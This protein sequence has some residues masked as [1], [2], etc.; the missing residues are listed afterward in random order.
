MLVES[1]SAA[2][3]SRIG[4]L[5]IVWGLPEPL[6]VAVFEEA[7]ER[8]VERHPI[9]RTQLVW[10]GCAEPFQEVVRELRLPFATCDWTGV[11]PE[12]QEESLQTF[13]LE[14]R[15]RGLDLGQAPLLRVTVAR[16]GPA[17]YRV[18]LTLHHMTYDGRTVLALIQEVFA[19]YG[20]LRG[21]EGL[22]LSAPGSYRAY[23]E[24]VGRQD[25][26][27][28][29][30]FWRE[31]L[32]GIREPTPLGLDRREHAHG[33]AEGEAAQQVWF[34]RDFSVW[35]SDGTTAALLR[36]T[37]D[38][39]LTLNTLLLGA[40]SL[41]LSRY[42]GERDVLF[43]V[44]RTHRGAVE[45]GVAI[46]GPMMNSVPF[47]ATVDPQTS[48]GSWLQGL[49]AHWLA[50]RAGD[51]ATPAQIRS[52][53][54][55]DPLAPLFES[56]ALF[57]THEL[58]ERLRQQGPDWQNRSFRLFR[59][60]RLPVSVYGYY[61]K[62]LSLKVIFDPE[63]FDP[64]LMR[65]LLGHLRAAVEAMP[66][67]I[68]RGVGEL[69]LLTAPERRQLLA[70]WNDT[71]GPESGAA[72]HRRFEEHARRAP[73][74]LAAVD[75]G[76]ACS[77]GEMEARANQLAW[78]LQKRGVRPGSIVGVLLDRSIEEVQALLGILK[79]GGAC[80]P[81]EGS[82]PERVATILEDADVALLLT[83]PAE[84][85]H[86]RFPAA[87]TLDLGAAREE[88]RRQPVSPPPVRT[89]AE[90][91][92]YVFYTSGS[93]GR[94]KGVPI[95]HRGLANLIEWHRDAYGILSADRGSRLAGLGFDASMWELWPFWS[96]GGTVF[97]PPERIR[98]APE[99][100]MDWWVRHEVTVANAATPMAE[101]LLPL[102]WPA[103]LVIRALHS[104]GDTLRSGPPEDLPF[105]FFN[106][107]GPTE[108]TC[109]ATSWEV[110]PDGDPRR[111]GRPPG[112]GRPLRNTRIYLLDPELRP[113]PIGVRGEL[114]IAGHG[115]AL[116]YLGRPE[117]TAASFV[118]DPYGG[119]GE[120]MYRTGDLARFHPDGSLEFLGR[121]DYQI[122]VRGFRIEPGEI[123][124][125][126]GRYPALEASA[127]VARDGARPG[128]KQLV[129]FV[130]G[131]P[132]SA[133]AEDELK[134][135]LR[136]KLP[137]YMIPALFVRL[138]SLPLNASAKV[139]RRA[140]A[141]EAVAVAHDAGQYVPPDTALEQLL[142][143]IWGQVLGQERVGLHDD[144]YALGGHSLHIMQVLSSV[145]DLFP[146]EMPVERAF[147]ASTI[148]QLTEQ[149]F[150]GEF[151]RLLAEN[152]AETVLGR[153]GPSVAEATGT[154]SG[155]ASAR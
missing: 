8:V 11:P 71:A 128:D 5:Q 10:L 135:F 142:A 74:A 85:P 69:P 6:D 88:L 96:A 102:R 154:L 106:V 28:A 60:G 115:L 18:I 53:S 94:P 36:L 141:A 25:H 105:P 123:E 91:P 98:F 92:A 116:G 155:A 151:E 89:A 65:R 26:R 67:G 136:G 78:L 56:L 145:R 70:E 27:R 149:L 83:H 12:R 130:V 13:L 38:L 7:W 44:V 42:S 90:Q 104:G 19:W 63:C 125:V 97:L 127:V 112:I 118:P 81:L 137:A 1:L 95:P 16:L 86:L 62:R 35:L 109:A 37:Q 45:D 150:P 41:L 73:A 100:L 122:K 40:W 131:V 144:F 139:D 57:E 119:A 84:H 58:G 51:F 79:A 15:Q 126:L 9:L 143:R 47:R 101:R 99:E 33:S 134:E 117:L 49:R 24:W 52:C 55:L 121:R 31:S 111:R 54:E 20:A 32:R 76:G 22:Q 138:D 146:H 77:Y 17:D 48:L 34:C 140:L 93:S 153:T 108:A 132:G 30:E 152:V 107:Y 124:E 87:R 64:L 59:Q 80:L 82:A 114:A 103:G 2:A 113:V 4:L 3:G 68:E 14:D 110:L 129:A 66:D 120:R 72:V 147:L 133:V 23:V 39:G 29:E 75:P 148:S 46:L 21:G 61:E 50:M 43:G